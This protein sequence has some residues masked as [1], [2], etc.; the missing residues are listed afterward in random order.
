MMIDLQP[1]SSNT[2]YPNINN[3]SVSLIKGDTYMD[4]REIENIIDHVHDKHPFFNI[5]KNQAIYDILSVFQDCCTSSMMASVLNPCALRSIIDH[6]DSL[7]VCLKWIDESISD[8]NSTV[9]LDISEQEYQNGVSLLNEYANPYSLICSGYISFSRGRLSADIQNNTVTFNNVDSTN[10]TAYNDI[11]REIFASTPDKFAGVINPIELLKATETLKKHSRIDNEMLCYDLTSEVIDAFFNIAKNQWDITK[12]LPNTWKFDNFSLEEYRVCWIWLCTLC[13]IHLFSNLNIE[14]PLIRLKNATIIQSKSNIIDY[15]VTMSGLDSNIV[16]AIIDY[17]TFNP[18]RKNGDIMYQPI[19]I[20]NNDIVI[21]APTL[22][23][24]SK[25]ERNLLSLVNSS[26][27]SFHS[28][29]VNDLEGLMVSELEDNIVLKPRQRIAKHKHLEDNLPDLDFA[30]LDED[31]N[32]V[33]LC[34]LK[35][36]TPADST[37]EVYAREDDITH[38]CEQMESIMAYAMQDREKFISKVFDLK[39]FDSIDL[40][41]C[42]VAKHN[43]RTQNNY[44]PVIDLERIK[45]L[46]KSMPTNS[47]FHIIRNHQYEIDLPEFTKITHQSVSYGNFIFNIPAICFESPITI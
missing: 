20:I 11:L 12:T 37:K 32:S 44:V 13:Y 16:E 42:V 41:C 4:I 2:S 26:K 28:K 47:A 22:F 18:K 3:Q 24:G 25:P 6:M 23:V 27:D 7:N 14:A 40:F 34:E 17:I 35:W 33:L 10:K 38:G 31:S 8:D 43:I 19:V 1:K 29:E 15:V 45:D 5:K 36:F 9:S 39:N 21:I 46:L 30:L